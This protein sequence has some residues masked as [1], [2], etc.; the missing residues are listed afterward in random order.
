MGLHVHIG[1]PVREVEP[2]VAA[3]QVLLALIERLESAGHRIQV[4]NLGG[5]WPISHFDGE[6]PPVESF[7]EAIVPLLEAR[8]TAGMEVRLEPGRSILGNSGILV[9][10]VQH[11]KEGRLKRFVICD[12]GMHT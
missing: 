4:L 1:S 12:A 5:G 2:Y 9:T 10:R 3:V 7:A 11:I 8:A 6:S